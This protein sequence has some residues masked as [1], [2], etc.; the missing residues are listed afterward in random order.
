ME[1]E[2]KEG[3]REVG[4]NMKENCNVLDS[5]KNDM[6]YQALAQYYA[7]PS[8][9]EIAGCGRKEDYHT[10]FIGWILSDGVDNE[11]GTSHHMFGCEPAKLFVESLVQIEENQDICERLKAVLKMGIIHAKTDTQVSAKINPEIIANY[12]GKNELAR[13]DLLLYIEYKSS[14][15]RRCLPVVIE[16][17]VFA[18]E[19]TKKMSGGNEIGQTEIYYKVFDEKFFSQRYEGSG[20]DVD[21]P[22]FVYWGPE[23]SSKDYIHYDYQHFVVEV[24]EKIIDADYRSIYLI[25]EYLRSCVGSVDNAIAYPT[26]VNRNSKALID[27]K[28]AEILNYLRWKN[29]EEGKSSDF[30]KIV[31]LALQAQRESMENELKREFDNCY[32]NRQTMRWNIYIGDNSKQSNASVL[33]EVGSTLFGLLGDD[34]RYKGVSDFFVKKKGKGL[35]GKHKTHEGWSRNYR[36]NRPDKLI[37]YNMNDKYIE[38]ADSTGT[39]EEKIIEEVKELIGK[40]QEVSFYSAPGA[41]QENL[42]SFLGVYCNESGNEITVEHYQNNEVIIKTIKAT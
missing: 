6:H 15:K 40:N 18:S 38:F 10:N 8:T 7:L 39:N 25:Q 4:V 35:Y 42:E 23:C 17:K 34:V 36:D 1:R 11:T 19:T 28:K 5:I 30:D 16:N 21:E 29:T 37:G 13:V 3:V 12:R 9:W 27:D 26:V 2:C 33:R 22:V 20:I 14:D 41:Y 32:K 31:L 24:L